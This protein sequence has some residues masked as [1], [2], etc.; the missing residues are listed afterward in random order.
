MP[1]AAGYYF[2]WGSFT[3]THDPNSWFGQRM[4]NLGEQWEAARTTSQNARANLRRRFETYHYHTGEA[5]RFRSLREQRALEFSQ[6]RGEITERI[7]NAKHE[8]REEIQQERN[9]L[10]AR[11]QS[12]TDGLRFW[13]VIKLSKAKAKHIGRVA[14]HKVQLALHPALVRTMVKRNVYRAGLRQVAH[15]FRVSENILRTGQRLHTAEAW[16]GALRPRGG[17]GPQAGGAALT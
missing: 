3:G 14:K 10:L 1:S 7:R 15:D 9:I 4:G 16:L 8:V 17:S 11:Y 5:S 6:A 13:N 2:D 12:D